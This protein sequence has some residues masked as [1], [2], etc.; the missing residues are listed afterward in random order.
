MV[1][2]TGRHLESI[3]ALYPDAAKEL[4]AWIKNVRAARWQNIFELRQ[5]YRDADAV[6]GYVI[7]DVR[8]N[9]SRLVTVV[10]FAKERDGKT[11]QGHVYIRSLLTHRQ[12]DDPENWDKEFGS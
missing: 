8:H 3:A 9:R 7:F 12:Y 5:L 1:V 11:T 2:V 10:H 6:N 4:A